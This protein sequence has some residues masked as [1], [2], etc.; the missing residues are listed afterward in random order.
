MLLISC[1]HCGPRPEIE[2][3]YGGEAHLTR[4][5]EQGSAA[6]T[7]FLYLRDNPKGWH[8]ERWRHTAGCGRYFNAVRHTVRDRIVQTYPAGEPRPDLASLL[9]GSNEIAD[10]GGR[11]Q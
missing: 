1:P 3:R 7:A 4:P 9:P 10:A 5:A 8:F 6:W 2:F 11:G